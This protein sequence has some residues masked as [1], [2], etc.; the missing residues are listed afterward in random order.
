MEIMANDRLNAEDVRDL[1]ERLLRKPR[2]LAVDGYTINTRRVLNGL[3]KA[4]VE[5]RSIEAVCA[6]LANV[7][8]SNTLREALNQTLRVEDLRQ[9]EAEFNAALADC[10]GIGSSNKTSKL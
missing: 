5:K 10:T 6:D 2:S 3:L 9:H 4:A 7:V 1:T 8:D